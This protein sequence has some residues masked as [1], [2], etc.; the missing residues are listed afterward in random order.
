MFLLRKREELEKNGVEDVISKYMLLYHADY[1]RDMSDVLNQEQKDAG[2]NEIARFK[3]YC[4][5]NIEHYL[6]NKEFC[7]L[8][9]CVMLRESIE[10]YCYEALPEGCREQFLN[11]HSTQMKLCFAMQNG[12]EY[13]EIFSLL[14]LIYNDPLHATDKKDLRQTLYSRLHNNTIK[15]MIVKVKELCDKCKY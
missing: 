4:K 9:V 11:E 2:W 14:S 10:R 12:V 7:P 5:S 6:T 15:A 3:E 13:P 1:T 8:A